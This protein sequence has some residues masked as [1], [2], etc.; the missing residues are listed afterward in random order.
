MGQTN[1]FRVGLPQHSHRIFFLRKLKQLS[2]RDIR[3]GSDCCV[4]IFFCLPISFQFCYCTPL[5]RETCTGK[6][7]KSTRRR[8]TSHSRAEGL[9]AKRRLNAGLI[10]RS[11]HHAEMNE[12]KLLTQGSQMVPQHGR[13]RP[14]NS[15]CD[16]SAQSLV[17][18]SH[19][20]GP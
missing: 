11:A 19:P 2:L 20:I 3:T 7:C 6:T 8:I 9:D 4:S 1:N 13:P 18:G 14:W 16:Q 10:A 12:T 15:T 5:C 17:N